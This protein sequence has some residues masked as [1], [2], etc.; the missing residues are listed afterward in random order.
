MID[1]AYLITLALASAGMNMAV[2][3]NRAEAPPAAPRPV[4]KPPVVEGA[5]W[6]DKQGVIH[7]HCVTKPVDTPK[8]AK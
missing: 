3:D 6:V 8:G 2:V 4:E 5:C 7:G 1:K